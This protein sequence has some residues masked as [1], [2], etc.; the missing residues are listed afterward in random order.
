MN[1]TT[2]DQIDILRRRA[3]SVFATEAHDSRSD[4]Y[5]FIPTIDVIEPLLNDGF[6]VHKVTENRFK[7]ESKYGYVK[8]QLRLRNP[9]LAPEVGG[10]VPEVIVTNS[11]DGTSA[12]QIRGGIYRLV[13]SNGLVIGN[14]AFNH[15]VRHAG[16]ADD[17]IEGVYT[18]I[19]D[20]PQALETTREWQGIELS[21]PEQQLFAE[22]ASL[23]RWD[24]DAAGNLPVNPAHLLRTRRWGDNG[25]DLF[26]IYNRAQEAIIKGGVRAVGS[27][28]KVS[29][30]RAVSSID[31]DSKLNRALWNLAEGFAQ[32]KSG[33]VH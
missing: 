18:V 3:P 25:N 15:S 17:V 32:L 29:R 5:R 9:S 31:Q 10:L 2:Q 1:F 11:H 19:T 4:K 21:V 6:V 24:A 13:C 26:S 20:L 12:F 30:S 23:L 27:T 28:G 14:D 33:V 7:D 22:S 8:H 16:R